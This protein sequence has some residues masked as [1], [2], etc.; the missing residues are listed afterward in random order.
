MSS[1]SPKVKKIGLVVAV[2]C[3]A[4]YSQFI[5]PNLDSTDGPSKPRQSQS[6]LSDKSSNA[7][8]GTK[9]KSQKGLSKADQQLLGQLKKR[10]NDEM[11]STAGLRYTRG[12]E[13]GHR[14]KHVQRHDNDIPNREGSHGVF[15]GDEAKMLAVIDEAYLLVKKKDQAASIR[16]D[17]NRSICTVDLHRDIGFIGGATGKR[18]GNP[19]VQRVRLILEDDRLITAYPVD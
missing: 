12:S 7:D 1:P 19:K 3:L 2:I 11:V 9:S 4:I 17:R 5:A 15:S 10:A 6:D 8:V 14:L 16:R 13:E 18:K